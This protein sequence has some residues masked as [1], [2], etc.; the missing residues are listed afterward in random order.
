MPLDEFAAL[1]YYQGEGVYAELTRQT[2][3]AAHTLT[4]PLSTPIKAPTMRSQH[5]ARIA[6][7][8]A[9]RNG[10]FYPWGCL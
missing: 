9:V 3:A 4:A 1:P 10:F 5:D 2:I 8:L 7:P 6:T